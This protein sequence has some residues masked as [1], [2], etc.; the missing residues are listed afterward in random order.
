MKQLTVQLEA[1]TEA[2]L[3]LQIARALSDDVRRGRLRPGDRLPSSRALASQLGVHRNTALAAYEEL[4]AEGWIT[5][6]PARGTFVSRALPVDKPTRFTRGPVRFAGAPGFDI[7]TLDTSAP[8][9]LGPWQRPRHALPLLGGVPDLR[10][11]PLVALGRAYRRALR[12]AEGRRLLDYGDP[13]GDPRL[14]AAL[15]ELL[16]RARGVAAP[17]EGVMVVRG[18][19]EG[20][21]LTARRLLQPGDRVAVESFGYRPAWQALRM[22]GAELVPIRVDEHGLDVDALEKL[23]VRAV[24]LTPHHQ[25]P[26]TVTLPAA[27]RL[28]LLEMARKRRMIIIEDDYDHE[29]HYEGRPILPLASADSAGVV[30]YIGTLSKSFAPGLRLGYVAASPPVIKALAAYRVFV[31]RQG[32]QVSERAVATLL[33]DGELERQARRAKRVYRD[34]RAILCELLER[35]LGDTLSFDVPSGGMALWAHAPGIDV[36]AWAARALEGGVAFQTARRFTFDGVPRP[37]MRMGFAAC[38]ERE[39]REAVRRLRR[40][41][42]S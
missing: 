27:R 4:A 15:A 12:G 30:V 21:Y 38:D 34:R 20:V 40:T 26:T 24:Y 42:L 3:F 8:P 37:F 13:L 9:D 25:Y 2:P 22:G 16:R 7:P 18:S 32:D 39:L 36:D 5:R 6:E 19:Q 41:L 23:Q 35:E 14:R 17:V 11:A 1:S 28:K 33:E 29:F 10:L 31:D